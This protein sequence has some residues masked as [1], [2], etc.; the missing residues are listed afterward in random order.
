MTEERRAGVPEVT[1]VVPLIVIAG[2]TDDV[3]VIVIPVAVAVVGFA[4]ES[5]E[6]ITTVTT[7]PLAN[8]LFE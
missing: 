1:V 8:A 5:D 7:S 6:V 3:I 2:L 4:Q